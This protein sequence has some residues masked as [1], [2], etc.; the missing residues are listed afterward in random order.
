MN[1]NEKLEKLRRLAR[2]GMKVLLVVQVLLVA[3]LVLGAVLV[4][5]N[6]VSGAELGIKIADVR[7][8]TQMAAVVV[9]VALLAKIVM[10]MVIL[11]LLR[12]I[13][14]DI[15]AEGT[16]F[17]QIHVRR[18]R[19]IAI[20]VAVGAFIHTFS[21]TIS[22]LTVALVIWLLAMIFDYGCVLQQESDETL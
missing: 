11:Q 21:S 20:L 13:L 1:S 15:A 5:G 14:K 22:D 10:T 8:P 4:A 9:A 17:S 3:V 2:I 7:W 16:P 18:M 19:Y 12:L 6:F